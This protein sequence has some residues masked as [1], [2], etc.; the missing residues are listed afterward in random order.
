MRQWRYS[1]DG[2][3]TCMSGTMLPEGPLL[4]ESRLAKRAGVTAP[5]L[6]PVRDE[7]VARRR[8]GY[9][10]GLIEQLAGDVRRAMRARG[11]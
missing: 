11:R 4:P 2:C 10:E 8:A 9:Q 5:E 1:L 3:Q 7:M 6:A